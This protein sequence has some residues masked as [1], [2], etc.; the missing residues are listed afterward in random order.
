MQPEFLV[1]RAEIE[2]IARPFRIYVP[3]QYDDRRTW[4]AVVFLHGAGERGNDPAAPT[5]VG[6]G[7]S[8]ARRAE[9]YPAIVVFPQCPRESHWSA[10]EARAIAVV[11]LATTANEFRID[12]QRVALTG[13]S[14]GAAGAWQ[15]AYEAPDR[16]VSLAPIC[17]WIGERA[18]SHLE[19]FAARIAGIPTWIFHGDRDDIV[20]VEE[21]RLASQALEAAGADVRYTEL[22]G[23]GHNSWDA[24]YQDSGLL[25]WMITTPVS[26][27]R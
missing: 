17:G 6:I 21:S 22:R 19:Q 8:L 11:A 18:K 23:V 14:M 15:L 27:S 20:P 7:P 25:D 13:I 2:G 1:R 10:V 4:P 9:P 26:A 24:A 5:N 16:F 3:P 12:Q